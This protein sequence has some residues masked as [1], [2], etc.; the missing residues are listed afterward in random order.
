LTNSPRW[1]IVRHL[2]TLGVGLAHEPKLLSRTPLDQPVRYIGHN[3]GQRFVIRSRMQVFI[4]RRIGGSEFWH[5]EPI[6]SLRTRQV[7]A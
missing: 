7:M 4:V 3:P 5:V 2:F 6:D 1:N